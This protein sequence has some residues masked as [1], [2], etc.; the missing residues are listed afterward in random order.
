MEEFHIPADTLME[1]AGRLLADEI[2]NSFGPVAGKMVAVVAG[3]GN[4]GGDGLVVARHLLEA[5]AR[6]TVYLL[7]PPEKMSAEARVNL[8]R[9]RSSAGRVEFLNEAG[10]GD[11][12]QSLSRSDLIV[13][14]L[15]G[16][17][18]SSPVEGLAA[19]VIDAINESGRPVIAADLPS[20]IHTDTGRV[21]G[22]AIKAT[23]TVA[24]ALPKRGL[25]LYPGSDFVGRLKVA[26]IGIPPALV[27]QLPGT[28]RWFTS[29][30]AGELIRRRSINSHKGTFGHM[31]VIAGSSGKGGAAVMA[32]LSG[33]RV[34]AGLVTLGHPAGLEGTLPDRPLEIMTLPLPQTAERSLS[35]AALGSLLEFAK[36]KS[37]AAIGPGLSVHPE[38]AALI[39]DLITHLAVPMVIDADGLNVL[40]GHLDLL[41]RARSPIVLTPHPGEM[42]R[43]IGSTVREVQAD[44]VGIA[45]DFVGR[46]PVTLV[47]KG[48]GTIVATPSGP[49]TINSTGNP[50]MAT[51][52][53]GDVLTGVVAGL[54]AQ[55]YSPD[56]ASRLGVYLHGLAGDLASDEIGEIGFL[57]GDVIRLLP[58]AITKAT[59]RIN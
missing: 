57:A 49:V 56:Q 13:D 55:G 7:A 36:D 26:D 34:G 10:L 53:T 17:G 51:A 12:F 29:A 31:V 59:A 9:F 2:Q 24:F 1:N 21:M 6:I 20:G 22:T 28:I 11:L 48:A 25:L 30:E 32:S 38:T 23:M 14:A 37:V 16:T 3:K 50:G 15:F 40:V 5:A 39:H 52:G 54:I 41:N 47:L 43:L 33:L 19:R 44:R 4:N 58:A 42:A 45:T 18:I 8:E 35:R 46:Y 27:D